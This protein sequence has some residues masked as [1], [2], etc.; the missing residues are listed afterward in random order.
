M[1]C[2]GCGKETAKLQHVLLN[3]D[4]KHEWCEE[5][6]GKAEAIGDMEYERAR[7]EGGNE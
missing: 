1:I 5:C 4:D 7:E 3:N 6:Y 2:D